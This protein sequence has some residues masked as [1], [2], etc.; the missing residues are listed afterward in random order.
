MSFSSLL[1]RLWNT[2][3]PPDSDDDPDGENAGFA[4]GQHAR[5]GMAIVVV[6]VSALVMWWIVA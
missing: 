6:F 2:F 1:Q 4:W 5:L 3:S